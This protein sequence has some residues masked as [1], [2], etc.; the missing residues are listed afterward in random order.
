M[1][2]IYGHF[3]AFINHFSIDPLEKQMEIIYSVVTFMINI[4]ILV[5]KNTKYNR[6]ILFVSYKCYI[7]IE[8]S[9]QETYLKICKLSLI[10]VRVVMFVF[11]K[12]SLIV[13]RVVNFVF[14]CYKWNDL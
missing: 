11:C 6:Y 13:V 10:V 14:C 9:I 5:I 12:L 4:F 8:L 3:M 1:T 2:A 7:N